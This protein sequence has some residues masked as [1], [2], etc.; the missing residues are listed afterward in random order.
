MIKKIIGYIGYYGLKRIEFRYAS[1]AMSR[2]VETLR[3]GALRLAGAQVGQ[4]SF[5]RAGCDITFPKYLSI[6]E[7][8]KINNNA[9]LYLFDKFTIGSN[10]EIGPEL[11]VYTGDH[12][13]SDP[14]QPLAKQGTYN[15]PVVIEND[16]YIGSR[17]TLLKG[18]KI[19]SR[20]VVAAGAVVSGVLESGY[21]Y[22]GIPAKK[23]KKL[24]E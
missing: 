16:V 22:G 4:N 10:V 14:A 2:H 13:I 5:V 20:V 15:S 1:L 17:V 7:N 8:S 21:I 12:H 9:G 6:A 11:L 24:D 19:E 23:L 18:T 3:Q